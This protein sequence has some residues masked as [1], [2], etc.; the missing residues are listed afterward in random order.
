MY[1]AVGRSPLFSF[2][3]RVAASAL[4]T[5]CVVVSIKPQTTNSGMG[6]PRIVHKTYMYLDCRSVIG[7]G[8]KH[9]GQLQ[10]RSARRNLRVPPPVAH[11]SGGRM[12]E[13]V[14]EIGVVGSAL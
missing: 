12:K 3:I 11:S 1:S 13:D 5:F 9:D 8:D 7:S 4:V 14:A 10:V 6:I 2:V